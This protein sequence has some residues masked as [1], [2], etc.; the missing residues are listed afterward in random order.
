MLES[1][2]LEVCEWLCSNEF[3]N[4]CGEEDFVSGYFL[5]YFSQ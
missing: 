3:K 4:F 5:D 2:Y 1:F